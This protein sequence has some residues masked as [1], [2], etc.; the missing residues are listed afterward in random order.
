MLSCVAVTATRNRPRGSRKPAR[1]QRIPIFRLGGSGG[2][3][4]VPE[5]ASYTPALSFE[6]LQ[7]GIDNLRHD[8]YLSPKFIESAR[9]QIVRLIAYHGEVESL[10]AAESRNFA[11]GRR[12]AGPEATSPS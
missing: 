4:E 12:L 5:L 3:G 11:S 2:E 7:V 6:G 10:L 8:V 1:M 9:A